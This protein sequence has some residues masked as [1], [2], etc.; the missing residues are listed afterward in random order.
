MKWDQTIKYTKWDQ[1]KLPQN[2]SLLLVYMGF[3]KC[4]LIA[5]RDVS[6]ILHL[7]IEKILTPILF[8]CPM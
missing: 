2:R 4:H 5:L 6:C 3:F 8:V 7:N 1:T